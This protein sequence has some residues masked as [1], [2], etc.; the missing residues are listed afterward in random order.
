MPHF[1]LGHFRPAHSKKHGQ[2]DAKPEITAV[3][4]VVHGGPAA[5][6]AAG[7]RVAGRA[8]EMAAHGVRTADG[9]GRRAA[10]EAGGIS[11]LSLSL[12]SLSVQ[13]PLKYLSHPIITSYLFPSFVLLLL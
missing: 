6:L 7:K 8:T 13:H 11:W 2:A 4:A 1:A 12:A 10:S 3:V 9:R 5:R